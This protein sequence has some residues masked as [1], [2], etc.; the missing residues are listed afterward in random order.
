M[1]IDIKFTKLGNTTLLYFL[2][3]RALR[4]DLDDDV[5]DDVED[6]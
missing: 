6:F 3:P 5:D 2:A 1:R 4:N